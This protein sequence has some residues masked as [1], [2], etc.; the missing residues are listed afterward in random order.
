MCTPIL[1]SVMKDI[2]KT[3]GVAT[4]LFFAWSFC[5]SME[6]QDVLRGAA[7]KPELTA[8]LMKCSCSMS[9]AMHRRRKLSQQ[10]NYR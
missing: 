2:L 7:L 9:W 1:H 8:C 4:C 10:Q 6:I 5:E 3:F